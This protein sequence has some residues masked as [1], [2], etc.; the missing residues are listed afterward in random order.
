MVAS[1][2]RNN[3]GQFENW[4]MSRFQKKPIVVEAEQFTDETKNR[5]YVWARQKQNNVWHSFDELGQPCLMIPTSEGEMR[6]SLNDWLIV[7]PNPTADRQLYPCKPD[8]FAATYELVK[9]N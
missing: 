8:I 9:T 7:E 4:S 6:C 5:V 3:N 2:A 1:V